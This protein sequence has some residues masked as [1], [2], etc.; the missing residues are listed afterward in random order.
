M[1]LNLG[2]LL[3]PIIGGYFLLTR[4]HYTRYDALR[5][6]GYHIFFQSAVVGFFF[7]II[8][9]HLI[10]IF[11]DPYLERLNEPWTSVVPQG[12]RTAVLS[13]LLG[14]ASSFVFNLFLDNKKQVLRNIKKHGR[15]LEILIAESFTRRKI[16]E[17]SL[18]SGKSYIGYP[19]MNA[20][21][22]PGESDV[23]LVPIASGHRNKD[24][25]E[26]KITNY[27]A[28]AFQKHFDNQSDWLELAEALRVVMPISEIVT[29]RIFIPEIYD[30]FQRQENSK[31]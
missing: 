18:K 4:C 11:L 17:I 27:Y 10:M 9:A 14:L 24:T 12:Y 22:T 20:K 31:D 30:S 7:L 1:N 26:L 3:L 15:L 28:P 29:A 13:A 25:Q 8:P 6:S 5:R 2:V 21:I 23:E 16:V 19:V